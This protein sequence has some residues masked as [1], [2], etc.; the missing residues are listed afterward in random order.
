MDWNLIWQ[1]GVVVLAGAALVG[2]FFK[3]I[4][5]GQTREFKDAIT[6]V[7][8]AA[9]EGSNYAHQLEVRIRALEAE[10]AMFKT[11]IAVLQERQTQVGEIKESLGTFGT[12]L[13][14]VATKLE[15]VSDRLER[16]TGDMKGHT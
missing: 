12:K 4:T 14:S 15:V 3:W 10:N 7:E 1:F 5:D 8:R 9:A 11:E 13:D 16:I 6:Q 2:G